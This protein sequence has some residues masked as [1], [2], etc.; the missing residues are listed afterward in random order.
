MSGWYHRIGDLLPGLSS[1][2][3]CLLPKRQFEREL[4]RERMRTARRELPFCLLSIR[5]SGSR[6]DRRCQRQLSRLLL[7]SLRK[8][9]QKGRLGN[10]TIGVLLVDTAEA[11][12]RSALERLQGIVA[13]L[14]LRTEMRLQA[15]DAR[16]WTPSHDSEDSDGFDAPDHPESQ[17]SSEDAGLPISHGLPESVKRGVDIVGAVVGLV[18]AGPL[19][20]VVALAIRRTSPGPALF[21][22]QREGRFGRPFTIYKL[23]TMV[24][25]AEHQLDAIRP[26]SERDG[27]AFKMRNDPRVTRLGGWLRSTCIDELPQLWNVLRG[28][29]SLVGPRP[30]PL[31]ESRSCQT[32]QRRRLDIRPGLTCIWQIDKRR[33]ENFDDWM[34]MDLN[35]VDDRTMWR[36]ITLLLR[37]VAVPLLR[38]GG[39]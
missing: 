14:G 21:R 32:W 28:D 39:D 11:G 9:D 15:F 26:H 5:L 31:D 4:S 35:Y 19:I 7:R 23:R 18:V 38:R 30:L 8:T 36:D 37:T 12:G 17:P 33:A 20:G 25:D 27:P 2:D 16:G 10:R 1:W 29:M 6:V 3:G 22:Q 13:T 24:I 34:R